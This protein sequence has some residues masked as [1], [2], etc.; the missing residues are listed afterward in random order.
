MMGK[1]KPDISNQK[2]MLYTIFNCQ[3]DTFFR[4]L[5]NEKAERLQ[6]EGLDEAGIGMDKKDE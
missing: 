3:V 2:A 1:K 5:N 6:P 4:R